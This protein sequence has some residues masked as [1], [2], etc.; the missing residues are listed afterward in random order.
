MPSCCGTYATFLAPTAASD[1]PR[2]VM[3]FDHRDPT[4]KRFTVSRII[5]RSREVIVE[6]VAKCNVAC[7]N[8]HGIRTNPTKLNYRPGGAKWFGVQPFKVE[9]TGS[10]PSPAPVH[11]KRA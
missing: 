1:S 8:S 2:F 10:L 7:G 3:Q 5:T 9:G 11:A 6:E 4:R